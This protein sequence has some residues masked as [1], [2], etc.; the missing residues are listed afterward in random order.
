MQSVRGTCYSGKTQNDV[1][2]NASHSATYLILKHCCLFSIILHF[3][4]GYLHL[5]FYIT[6]II[7]VHYGLTMGKITVPHFVKSVR[8]MRDERLHRAVEP[9]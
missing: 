5:P 4:Q 6:V 3:Y 2:L 8:K 7:T 1:L 9:E